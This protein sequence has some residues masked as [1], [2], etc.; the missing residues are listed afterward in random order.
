MREFMRFLLPILMVI[1]LLGGCVHNLY[2]IQKISEKNTINH[3]NNGTYNYYN[4]YSS[5]RTTQY[6]SD[7]Y[8]N[9]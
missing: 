7:D 5:T 2:H 8:P 9:N 6:N 4:T 1:V 3:Y